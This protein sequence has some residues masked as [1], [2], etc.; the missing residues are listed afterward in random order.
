MFAEIKGNTSEP[1]ALQT[2]RLLAEGVHLETEPRPRQSPSHHSFSSQSL[3]S[4]ALTRVPLDANE[5]RWIKLSIIGEDWVSASHVSFF[6]VA[7]R[8]STA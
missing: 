5:R 6:S 3:A 1:M 8:N 4:L 2:L 7:E